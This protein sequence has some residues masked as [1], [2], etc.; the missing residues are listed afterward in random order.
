MFYFA[1]CSEYTGTHMH[2]TVAE[3]TAHLDVIEAREAAES[4]PD[5]SQADWDAAD[6]AQAK[7]EYEAEMAIERHFETDMRLVE[8][9]DREAAYEAAMLGF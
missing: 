3:A 5:A 6:E 7:A 2:R 4:H 8:E 1:N 9:T